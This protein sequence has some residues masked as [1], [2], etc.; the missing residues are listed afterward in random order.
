MLW[1]L[2][3]SALLRPPPASP[4]GTRLQSVPHPSIR[5]LLTQP[6]ATDQDLA[7]E[8]GAGF[9]ICF[10]FSSPVRA[11]AGGS[12]WGTLAEWQMGKGRMRYLARVPAPRGERAE[13]WSATSC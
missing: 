2:E 8:A 5:A 6:A 3:G 9:W 1:P 11:R 7:P 4:L 12:G 10:S 13:A